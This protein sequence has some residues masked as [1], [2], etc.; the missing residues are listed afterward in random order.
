M[1]YFWRS[2]C[3]QPAE[4]VLALS[5]VSQSAA[6]PLSCGEIDSTRTRA[7]IVVP[8]GKISNFGAHK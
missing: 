6:D 2:T 5:V 3:N 8:A 1:T 4:A 7:S